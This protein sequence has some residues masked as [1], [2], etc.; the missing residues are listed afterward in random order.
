VDSADPNPPWREVIGVVREIKHFGPEAKV[1][2]M[3]VYVPQYQQPTP[4]LSFVINTMASE[5]VV[6][7]TAEKAIHDLD[8]EVPVENFATL[9]DL[10]DNYVSGRK[11]SLF[12]LAGFASIGIVLGIMGIY[13][14]V[15]NSII[16]RRRE[17]A[18]RM[19]LGAS[20]LSMIVLITKLGI[21]AA[22]GGILIGSGIVISLKRVLA[23]LLFGITA[24][25]PSV[26]L[27]SGVALILLAFLASLIP[28]GRLFGINVQQILRQ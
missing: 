17:I 19:A 6:K 22:L 25:D 27:A 15:A 7:K 13:G 24:L 4:V 10:L 14:V 23:S 8:G 26:Y 21:L 2:W 1:R 12:L 18:I 28:A 9:D 5:S 16:Q 20:R 3:Q 11:V